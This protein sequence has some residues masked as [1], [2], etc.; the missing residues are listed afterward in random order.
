MK[1]RLVHLYP[2]LMNI[3][4]DMG[5]VI[6]LSQRAQWRGIDLEIKNVS[7]GDKM[8]TE[9]DLLF[10]GGGQDTGQSL[11]SDDINQRAD[12]IKESIE[13]GLPALVICGGYQL[14]GHYFLTAENEKIPGIGVLDIITK[15][16]DV[17]MIGNLVIQS[18]RFGT[19][20]G[21]ENHSGQTTYLSAQTPLGRVS[22]GYGNN[23]RDKL[24]GVLY[25]NAIGTYMHG[26][27][28]PKNPQVADFLLLQAIRRHDKSAVLEPLDDSLAASAKKIA[29]Q[30]PR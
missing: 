12:Q 23:S 5:N 8:P 11:V 19:L 18:D 26:S 24:E 7:I 1:L 6:C 25:K 15:A 10:M 16:S 30:R 4:G 20:V 13:Q 22:K 3:Y 21:F 28:L 14:F 17:R 2:D 9:F 29:I 27:F